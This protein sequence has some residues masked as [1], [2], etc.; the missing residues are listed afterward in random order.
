MRNILINI[1]TRLFLL[2]TSPFLMAIVIVGMIV[3]GILMIIAIPFI[4]LFAKIE[5][6]DEVVVKWK[7]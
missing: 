3:M 5:I 1:G 6:N 7:Q 2:A 4:I